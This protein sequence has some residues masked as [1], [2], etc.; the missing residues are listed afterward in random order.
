[1]KRVLFHN[2]KSTAKDELILFLFILACIIAGTLMCVFAP[3]NWIVS[4]ASIKAFGVL[5]ILIGVMFIPGLIYRLFSNDKK[6]KK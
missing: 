6:A 5:W 3:A 2:D 4:S 1:M